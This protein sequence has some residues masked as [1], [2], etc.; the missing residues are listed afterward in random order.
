MAA[1]IGLQVVA[2]GVETRAQLA[3]LR[4]AQCT[5]YQGFLGRPPVD[6]ETFREELAIRTRDAKLFQAQMPAEAPPPEDRL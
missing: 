3:L 6:A 4:D 2:E 5:F 1:H